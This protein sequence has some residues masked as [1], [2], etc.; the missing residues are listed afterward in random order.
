MLYASNA[1]RMTGRGDRARTLADEAYAIVANG[2]DAYLAAFA[3]SA[4]GTAAYAL[5]DLDG[6]K[7]E[8]EMAARAFAALDA[9]DDEAL[10]LVNAARC[11]FGRGDLFSPEAAFEGGLTRALD[12]GN[13]YVEAHA[14]CQPRFIGAGSGPSN[15]CERASNESGGDHLQNRRHRTLGN[16]P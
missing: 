10:M 13:V 4:V 9:R 8:F 14:A 3:R 7:G 11:D 15:R 1:A 6:A 12:A 5:G 16:R 2:G